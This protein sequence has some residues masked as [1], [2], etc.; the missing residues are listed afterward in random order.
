[1]QPGVMPQRFRAPLHHVGRHQPGTHATQRS[2]G[3]HRFDRPPMPQR[4]SSGNQRPLGSGTHPTTRSHSHLLTLKLPGHAP[5]GK[6]LA[7]LGQQM[8]TTT[9]DSFASHAMQGSPTDLRFG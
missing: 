1:M 4:F 7:I 8:I 6:M 2:L 5:R 9:H 3:N